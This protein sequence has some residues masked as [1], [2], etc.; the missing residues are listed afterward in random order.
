MKKSVKIAILIASL[1]CVVG[2]AVC[3][4]GLFKINFDFSQLNTQEPQ[5]KTYEIT[6]EFRRI[7]IQTED[8]DVI[9]VFSD[10]DECRVVCQETKKQSHSVSVKEGLLENTLVIQEEDSRKWYDHIGFSF[11]KI[12]VTVYLP[13]NK[14][15]SL[16]IETDTGDVEI[17]DFFTFTSVNMETDTGDVSFGNCVV[18]AGMNIET[19][20]GDISLKGATIFGDLK[21]KT[22][23]G[24]VSCVGGCAKSMDV[25]SNTGDVKI[26]HFDGEGSIVVNSDTGDVTFY[27]TTAGE[28]IT[29]KTDTGDVEFERS[30]AASIFVETDTGDVEGSLLSEK[31]FF[32]ESDTGDIH[33]PRGTSGGRCEIRTDTGDIEIEI[34][35]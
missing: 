15:V 30:D 24:K 29:V 21:I 8:A 2:V 31:I 18:G 19:D 12:S 1:L 6:E 14:Y 28:S 9:F 35:E 22:D 33:V 13:Y 10:V 17:P 25:K 23:T 7:S 16:S 34:V 27:R 20:T 11:E 4:M 5:T 26:E 3:T 32:T